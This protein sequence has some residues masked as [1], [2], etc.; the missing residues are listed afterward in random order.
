MIIMVRKRSRMNFEVE[1]AVRVA[2]RLTTAD[3]KRKRRLMS[4]EELAMTRASD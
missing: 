4:D 1:V 2:E 3:S